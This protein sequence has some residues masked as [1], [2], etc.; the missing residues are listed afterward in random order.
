MDENNE[1]NNSKSILR[2]FPKINRKINYSKLQISNIGLYSITKPHVS[3]YIILLIK[4]YFKNNTNIT[5][6]DATGNVGGMTIRFALNFAKV[7][8]VEI[9]DTH[10]N[11]LNNNVSIYNLQSKVNI[12]CNDYLKIKNTLSQDAIFLDPPWG[13]TNYKSTESLNLNLSGIDIIDIINSLNGK[14]KIIVLFAPVNY[15]FNHLYKHHNFDN[16][17]IHKIYNKYNNVIKHYLFVF[18]NNSS[19]SK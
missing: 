15:N 1:Q 13:G 19:L 6:T 2:L 14:A 11:M 10:C 7:N 9:D 5:I 12:I 17:N 18:Y 4:R 8:S 3:N 16:L